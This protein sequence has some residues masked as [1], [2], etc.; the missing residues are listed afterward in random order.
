MS[1][2]AVWIVGVL[3][4]FSAGVVFIL[5]LAKLTERPDEP[6][7][8]IVPFRSRA[9]RF[10]RVIDKPKEGLRRLKRPVN[11]D[12]P[13]SVIRPAKFRDRSGKRDDA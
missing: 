1:Y 5:A 3:I 6:A 10:P 7:R 13:E 2:A 11:I 9:K 4:G 12:Q 8:H